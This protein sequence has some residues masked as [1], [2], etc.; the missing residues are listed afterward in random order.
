MTKRSL[1]FLFTCLIFFFSLQANAQ[2]GTGCPDDVVPK[3]SEDKK[4]WGYADLFGQWLIEPIYS[5]VSPFIEGKAIVQK[6]ILSGVI[7]C[8]GNVILQCKYEKLTSFRNGKV[9]AMEKGV[10]GLIGAKGQ[11]FQAPQYTEINPIVNSE[12]AWVKKNNV[13]GLF[14]EEKN[15]FTCQ[16]QFKIAQVMSINASLVQVDKNF[17]VLN[18]VNCGYLLPLE[19]TRVKK[20]APHDIIFEQNGKWGMFNDLG[21]TIINP[22]FDTIFLKNDELIQVQKAGKYGLYGMMGKKILTP[23]YE[24]IGALNEGFYIVK[25]NGR[26]GYANRVGK[27]LIKPVYEEAKPFRNKQAA[28]KKAGKWGVIDYTNKFLLKPEFDNISAGRGNYYAI[29]QGDKSYFYDFNFKKISEEGFEKI[30]TED[31]VYAVRI[32]KDGKYGY[33]NVPARSYVT[34]ERF[35]NAEPYVKG[36]AVVTN[37]N[38]MGLLDV[39]GKLI[40]PCQYDAIVQDGFQNKIIFRTVQNG[41]EGIADANGK[42]IL[43]NE[44]D[45]I[46]PALPNYLKVKK[47]GKYAILRTTGAAVTDFNYDFISSSFDFPDAPEWP[48][49]ASQKGKFGLINE[50]G[51]EVFPIKAKEMGYLGNGLYAAKEGKSLMLVNTQGKTTEIPYEEVKSFGDGM[52]PVK[53]GN[54]WGYITPAGEEKIKPQYEEA[55]KFANKLAAVKMKGKWGVTNRMGKLVVPIEYDSYTEDN[56][57][58]R[59]LTKGD[60]VYVLQPDGSLK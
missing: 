11:I 24:E 4:N 29:T 14:N 28:V 46:N 22:D 30:L 48:A 18:H 50:K 44:Y 2:K 8:E 23:E 13:W 1:A 27:V 59:K 53:T 47:N 55:E 39:N 38:K 21:K 43:P 54:K 19:L 40:L 52:A 16:P 17:G 60:K 15:N 33:Y 51:E 56:E 45:R 5:K 9:W 20:L 58:N 57:G 12:L 36:Y 49:M 10:W 37:G 42:I 31:T 32:K 35:D 25:Q 34:T 3:Y 26:Y 41:K 6:G 7:D